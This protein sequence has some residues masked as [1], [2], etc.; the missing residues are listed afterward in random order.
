MGTLSWRL[1][2]GTWE[3]QWEHGNMGSDE[4]TW[5]HNLGIKTTGM[6]APRL[7]NDFARRAIRPGVSQCHP[8]G[9]KKFFSK[10]FDTR[11]AFTINCT[12]PVHLVTGERSDSL[13]CLQSFPLRVG[14]AVASAVAAAPTAAAFLA[15]GPSRAAP[16]RFLRR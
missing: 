5:E 2:K 11:G 10:A 14:T 12:F 3:T 4:A 15:A 16:A 13:S 8:P 7:R 1:P 9:A 6:N